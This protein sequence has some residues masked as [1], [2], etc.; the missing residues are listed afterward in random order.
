MNDQGEQ[1]ITPP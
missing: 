1:K